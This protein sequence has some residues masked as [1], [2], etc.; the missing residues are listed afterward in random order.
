[1]EWRTELDTDTGSGTLRAHLEKV[2]EM[3]GTRDERLDP[4][5]LELPENAK[6]YAGT[7]LS[8][9]YECSAGR[10]QGFNGPQPITWTEIQSWC[11][12]NEVRLTPWE[13]QVLKSLDF[14]YLSAV[15]RLL[16][17]NAQ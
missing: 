5:A 17:R 10:Q 6:L 9:F 14:T 8:Y 16:D 2:E 4:P 3:T 7:L 15:Q 13:T 12:L 1:M 11:D